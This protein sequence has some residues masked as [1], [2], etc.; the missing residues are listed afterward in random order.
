MQDIYLNKLYFDIITCM[1]PPCRAGGCW[2][3]IPV[4][5]PM[6]GGAVGAF[7]YFLVVELHRQEP[8]NVEENNMEDRY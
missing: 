4:V 2:W 5:G 1:C 7:I 8:E 3:W 6:V